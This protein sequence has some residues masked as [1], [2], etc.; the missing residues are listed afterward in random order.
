MTMSSMQF[1]F[2]NTTTIENLSRRTKVWTLAVLIPSNAQL[3]TPLPFN[4]IIYP[5][6]SV[7]P[8]Q[9]KTIP[10]TSP[11]SPTSSSTKTRTFA[12]LH[13]KPGENPWDLGYIKNFKSVMG[14]SWYDWL[15]PIRFSPCCNHD[16]Y[17]AHFET[18][19]VVQRM[20]EDAGLVPLPITYKETLPGKRRRRKR[21]RGHDT[22]KGGREQR[23]R[24]HWQGHSDEGDED[25]S[26]EAARA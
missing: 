5:L 15:L 7:D 25:G 23:H 16:R 19:P 2:V 17:N 9:E 4:T 22:E 8:N 12:I 3:P 14:E 20:K 24:R 11:T 18:G 1:I 21:R 26:M 13:S 6:G 10:P